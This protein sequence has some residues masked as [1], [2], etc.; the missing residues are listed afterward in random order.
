MGIRISFFSTPKHRVFNYKPRYWDESKERL[1]ELEEKYGKSPE[2][3]KRYI[4]GSTIRSAY[5]N[6]LEGER[7]DTGRGKIRTFLTFATVIAA[8]LAAYYLA[9]GLAEL[10]M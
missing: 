10:L 3:P 8:M 7:R 9:Q 5:R 1:Q 4:P 6:G 2:K